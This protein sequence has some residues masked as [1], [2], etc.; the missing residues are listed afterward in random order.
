MKGFSNYMHT[1][2]QVHRETHS[3]TYTHNT[4][5]I[6]AKKVTDPFAVTVYRNDSAVSKLVGIKQ[7]A[8]AEVLNKLNTE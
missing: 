2:A 1:L 3:Q 4:V 7:L 8:G 6:L 5:S